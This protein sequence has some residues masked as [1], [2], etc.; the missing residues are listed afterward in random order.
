M[1][2]WTVCGCVYE[3]PFRL[4]WQRTKIRSFACLPLFVALHSTATHTHAFHVRMTFYPQWQDDMCVY[5]FDSTRRP[6][7]I[8]TTHSQI[9]L[10]RSSFKRKTFHYFRW[11]IFFSVFGTA[12]ERLQMAESR[13]HRCTMCAS[14]TSFGMVPKVTMSHWPF[15]WNQ[16][17]VWR[18]AGKLLW[19]RQLLWQQY[20]SMEIR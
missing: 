6:P 3:F 5:R 20:T 11:N 8:K 14:E 13:L 1:C 4:T 18:L 19:R 12:V 7:K 9:E 17:L 10:L 15:Q 16:M 2:H